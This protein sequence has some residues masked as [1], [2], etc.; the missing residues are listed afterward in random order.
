[1]QPVSYTHLDVYKR[2][3]LVRPDP[4]VIWD[5]PKKEKGWRK[6]HGNYPV[7]YTH[8]DVYKRQAFIPLLFSALAIADFNNFST[9]LEA[10]LG[11]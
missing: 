10:Y 6:M 1:M 11:L 2:Q 9:T 7:S 5:T 8:L 4:Q 3:L